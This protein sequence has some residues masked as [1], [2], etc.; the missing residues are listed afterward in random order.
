MDDYVSKPARLED[1]KAC[2]EKAK[3]LRQTKQAPATELEKQ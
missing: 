2:L 1:M 3:E